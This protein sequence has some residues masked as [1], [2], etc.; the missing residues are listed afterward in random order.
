MRNMLL[1]ASGFLNGLPVDRYTF[2]YHFEDVT[3]GAWEHSYSSG[4][5]YKE[6]PWENIEKDITDTSAHE[7]FHIVTPLNIH[8]EIVDQFNFVTPVISDHLWLYEGTTEWA[9]HM[10]LFRSRQKSMEDYFKTLRR[11]VIINNNYFNPNISLVELAR[12]SYTPEGHKQYANIYMKGALVAGLL[13]IRLLE[14]SNGERGLVD[15]INDLAKEY[16]P[17][18]PF[19]E[20]TFFDDFANETHPEISDFFNKYVKASEPLPFKEYY[21]KLGINFDEA[22]STFSLM[23]NPSKTQLDL[24]NK[25]MLQIVIK[26]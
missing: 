26:S 10:M 17:D 12:T 8:S 15:V 11:K 22:T 25:W 23:K 20:K 19:N 6:S 9:A 21:A 24:R 3:V 7:F 1:S 14:L 18:K 16:G 13:D 4:Y 2:L 5:V